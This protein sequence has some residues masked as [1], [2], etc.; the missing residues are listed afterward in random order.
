MKITHRY[1]RKFFKRKCWGKWHVRQNT[2]SSAGIYL[3]CMR[4]ARYVVGVSD[5]VY[6]DIIDSE[7]CCKR[8]LKT[9]GDSVREVSD[10]S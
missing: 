5:F 10:D 7:D 8:C 2:S 3:L 6:A 4:F 1:N 9:A